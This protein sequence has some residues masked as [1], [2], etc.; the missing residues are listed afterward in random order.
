MLV[1]EGSPM[2]QV[3]DNEI[4]AYRVDFEHERLI[5][6]TRYFHN[7]SIVELTDVVFSGYLTHMF[8]HE[9]KGS[10]LFDIE[11]CPL[12][13]FLEREHAMLE[14]NRNYAWPITYR[15][16][17]T[18]AELTSFMRE[19]GYKAFE[20]SSSY[21]LYGWVLAKRMDVIEEA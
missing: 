14:E 16:E 6:K 2:S 5:L 7:G 20:V 19:N 9:C 8:N 18:H 21:G 1:E 17:D 3:H 11:E 15:A 13:N 12:S 10:V 4:L